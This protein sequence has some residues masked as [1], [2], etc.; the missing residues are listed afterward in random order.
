MIQWPDERLTREDGRRALAA[1]RESAAACELETDPHRWHV[2]S[3]P[4]TN[5]RP[6][7]LVLENEMHDPLVF[8][9]DADGIWM[10]TPGTW[11][12]HERSADNLLRDAEGELEYAS[13]GH[14]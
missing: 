9:M 5:A 4:W 12:V 7:R 1:F 2:V 14:V 13:A 6:L 10:L 11:K 8:S 3:W